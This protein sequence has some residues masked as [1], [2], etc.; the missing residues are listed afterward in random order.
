MILVWLI[1][2]PCIGALLAGL[3]P[4]GRELRC[5]GV[6]L[7]AFAVNLALTLALWVSHPAALRLA[8]GGAWFAEFDRAWIPSLGIRFHLALDGLS[9]VLVALTNFL[10]LMAVAASWRDITEKV[11]FFHVN[12][13]W[14]AAAVIGVFLAV[15]LFLFYSFWELMLVPLYFLIGI[16]GHE[17][18]LYAAFKFFIFTQASSLLMLL[19]LLGLYFIHGRATGVYTFDYGALMGTALSPGTGM[20]LMLGFFTA[21]VIK[22]AAVPLHNWLPDAHT[23]APT[24]GSVILAGLVLKVGAYGLIRFAIPLF[25]AASAQFAPVAMGM[26]VVSILYG[27]ILAFAQ[28]DIKRLV[29]YTSVSHMG[30]V[31]LGVYAGSTV[32]LQGAVMV[33]LAHG[34]STSAL[35][36]LVGALSDRIGTREM[37][38]MGGL[39]AAAPRMSGALLVFA[40][41]SLGL[42]GFGNFV[43][44][45]LVLLGVFRM[46]APL[47]A[48]A[49]VS[50]VTAAIYS[51]WMFQR[52]CHGPNSS[53][54]V[55]PD[56][57]GIEAAIMVGMISVTVWLGI[58][59]GAV[60]NVTREALEA[61]LRIKP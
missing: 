23:Q 42:P 22:L 46:S 33:M 3:S 17:R 14:M 44:E 7:A 39:W 12:L 32:A 60:L 10:G 20:W 30:F 29:A 18:R 26:G 31:L 35:F 34:I 1:S 21:F 61:V 9:L 43:G 24:A 45:F 15:D 4:R 27:A 54:G 11:R 51:L 37:G 25:P 56:L 19:A 8:G 53:G 2:V 36:I 6:T 16:W 38:R 59:P 58:Y 28:T 5:R 50:L 52:V 49:A 41:A 57:S 48:V 40:L 55:I 47:A 13:L